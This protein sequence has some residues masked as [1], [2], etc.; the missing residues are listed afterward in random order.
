M[1]PSKLIFFLV[2]AVYAPTVVL[3]NT[4]SIKAVDLVEQTYPFDAGERFVYDVSYGFVKAGEAELSVEKIVRNNKPIYHLVGTGRS[5]GT[6]NFFFKVEDRYE[7]YIDS[8]TLSPMLFI[9]DIQEGGY[10]KYQHY[11]FFQ[12]RSKVRDQH[13][14]EY[15][16]VKNTQDMLSG[17]L[18]CRSIDF[19]KLAVDQRVSFDAFIDR[20]LLELGLRYDGIENI[21]V[22]GRD[23]ACYKLKPTTL[24]G[25]VFSDSEDLTVYVSADKDRVPVLVE[26]NLLIGKLKMELR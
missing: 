10:A 24:E 8:A 14:D 23:R 1:K 17:V 3:D 7:S 5:T 2:G 25:R 11:Q 12:H 18:L 4:S 26:A 21:K 19:S 15:S 20:E 6:F 13:K 9:R 22:G 16:I